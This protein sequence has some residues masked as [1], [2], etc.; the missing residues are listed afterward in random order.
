MSSLGNLFGSKPKPV[1]Q[2][3]PAAMPDPE[4]A[5]AEAA[6]RA[7]RDVLARAGRQSTILTAPKTRQAAP[8]SGTPNFDSFSAKTLG[9]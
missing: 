5:G 7:R 2:E 6:A 3:A 8:A 9:S 4:L 1:T